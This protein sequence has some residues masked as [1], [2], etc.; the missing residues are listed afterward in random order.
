MDGLLPGL[1]LDA[2]AKVSTRLPT[3]ELERRVLEVLWSAG[4]PMTAREVHTA[5]SEQRR[6][7]YTT[8]MTTLVRLWR[9]GALRRDTSGR[10]FAYSAVS[11]RE[12]RAAERM[13]EVLAATEDSAA[14]LAHFVGGLGPSERR[15]LQR[16]LKKLGR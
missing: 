11:T 16:L 8:V 5:L 6:I 15:S 7:A 2:G 4:D 10:A 1:G 3:G 13:R 9:K 14:A 12:E